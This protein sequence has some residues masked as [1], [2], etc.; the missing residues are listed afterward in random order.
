MD[1]SL[2][3]LLYE[4]LAIGVPKKP[5]CGHALANLLVL[6]LHALAAVPD[7]FFTRQ[8]IDNISDSRGWG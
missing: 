2:F 3:C 5:N 6:K 1:I 8:R 7:A 4:N